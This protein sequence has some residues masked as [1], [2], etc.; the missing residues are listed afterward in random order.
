MGKL[1]HINGAPGVGKLTI[2]RQMASRLNARVLDNHAIYNVAFALTEFRSPGF[3]DAVRASRAAA[4]QQVLCLPDDETVIF[5]DAY[6]DDSS[7][8]WESW[9]AIEHLADQRRWPFY[10]VALVCKAAEHRR[11]IVSAERAGRGK[12]QDASY[13]D[14]AIARR[15]IERKG[16]L[17]KRLDITDLSADAAGSILADWVAATTSV[18]HRNVTAAD[19]RLS[20]LVAASPVLTTILNRWEFVALPNCWL[21]GSAIAQT[22]WNA[23][24][25]LSPEYGLADIDLVYFDDDDL[26]EEGEARA[27]ERIQG[28]FPDLPIR[29]DAKNEARVHLWY[30]AK[31]G[32]PIP[33]Y[34]S[35]EHAISTFP[36]TAG[37]VA[38]RPEAAGLSIFAPFGLHDL[39]SCTVRPNKA[40][41]TQA[42]YDAKV[43]RWR[44]CWPMLTIIDWHSP[45]N[46]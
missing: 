19:S 16:D 33:P 12:L 1:I 25:G 27:A 31:F 46:P 43:A 17:S 18:S 26:S 3:Y 37:A 39:L 23:A 28:L 7:W 42:I 36:T 41:I 8:G 13:V 4:Y 34:R 40:Q 6:F 9:G 22:A 32:Y 29:I 35:S 38:I 5:T 21:S 15:L 24:F 2:A 20:S 11:R 30:E 45:Q 14:R 10:S 44:A